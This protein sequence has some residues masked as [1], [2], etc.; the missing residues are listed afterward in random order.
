MLENRIATMVVMELSSPEGQDN[1]FCSSQSNSIA[2]LLAPFQVSLQKWASKAVLVSSI[3]TA[4]M[5]QRITD[6]SGF[7]TFSKAIQVHITDKDT[8]AGLLKEV[9]SLVP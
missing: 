9:S 3:L 8:I 5:Q 6:S 4:T 1:H 2:P 7:T